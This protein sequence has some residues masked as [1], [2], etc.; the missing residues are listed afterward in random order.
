LAEID[1]SSG[2]N[3]SVPSI[4]KGMPGETTERADGIGEG[5]GNEAEWPVPNCQPRSD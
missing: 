2:P 4:E 1:T 3:R 5:E